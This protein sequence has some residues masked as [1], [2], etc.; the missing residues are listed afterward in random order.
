MVIASRVCD[1][2]AK[3]AASQADSRSVLASHGHMNLAAGEQ[4]GNYQL[5]YKSPF[6][7]IL[8]KIGPKA[9]RLSICCRSRL[10][11]IRRCIATGTTASNH[12]PRGMTSQVNL[13]ACA[14]HPSF[15]ARA[16]TKQYV[17]I[18]KLFPFVMAK[19]RR[20]CSPHENE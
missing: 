8:M 16:L 15:D 19:R 14:Q 2:I 20:K 9:I 3:P 11:A 17:I 5:R 7:L 13:I 4:L 12:F 6:P 18:H 10:V 1:L